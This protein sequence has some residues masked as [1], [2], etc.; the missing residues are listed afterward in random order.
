MF[1]T[2]KRSQKVQVSVTDYQWYC[3]LHKLECTIS[4][5]NDSKELRK[6]IPS[7]TNIYNKAN[8]FIQRLDILKVKMC[9]IHKINLLENTNE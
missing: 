4:S 6:L 2:R 3:A 1:Y 7:V 5:I 9:L 8:L